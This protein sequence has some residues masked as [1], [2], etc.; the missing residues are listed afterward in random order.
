[1]PIL[2]LKE[3]LTE[4]MPGTAERYGE[5]TAEAQLL[6]HCQGKVEDLCITPFLNGY[7]H[8]LRIN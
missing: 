1:M 2:L 5:K 6:S 7:T 3:Y 4:E 8:K